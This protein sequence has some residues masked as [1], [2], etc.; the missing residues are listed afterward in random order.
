MDLIPSSGSSC[1]SDNT[2]FV[3]IHNGHSERSPVLWTG[4]GSD[5]PSADLK[6][7][8]NKMWISFHAG[9][10][11]SG[12]SNVIMHF[13]SCWWLIKTTCNRPRTR[14]GFTFQTE[15]DSSGCG[16]THHA[17]NGNITSPKMMGS[18]KYPNDAECIWDIEGPVGFHVVLTFFDR[19]DIEDTTSCT[20][21]YIMVTWYCYS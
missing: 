14:R 13:N 15:S 1:G 7:M 3:R 19:F 21:D 6:T 10:Y 4:C 9:D 2:D 5:R 12:Y 17:K 18:S 11:S 20:N 16:G 8:S